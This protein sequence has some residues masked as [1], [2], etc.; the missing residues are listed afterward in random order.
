MDD[1]EVVEYYT[2]TDAPRP[3][4]VEAR[5]RSHLVK[6]C[7]VEE[8]V[9]TVPLSGGDPYT[10]LFTCAYTPSISPLDVMKG[11]RL[12]L[13]MISGGMLASVRNMYS[14]LPSGKGLPR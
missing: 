9:E 1:E 4:P 7:V 14:F 8:D 12:H 5:R 13:S 2:E 3:V 11:V 6:A 10:P